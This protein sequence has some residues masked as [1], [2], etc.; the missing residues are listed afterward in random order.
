MGLFC[1]KLQKQKTDNQN[2]FFRSQGTFLSAEKSLNSTTKLYELLHIWKT[3]F[4]HRTPLV[5]LAVS[6]YLYTE[7]LHQILR[8]F[9]SHKCFCWPGQTKPVLHTRY[10]TR[11]QDW[12]LASESPPPTRK[13]QVC[14]DWSGRMHLFLFRIR[15]YFNIRSLFITHCITA[16][17]SSSVNV[18]FYSVD[19]SV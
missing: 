7:N 9:G 16:G 6:A 11:M 14:S 1:E 17:K 19:R 12:W 10:W 18:L 2:S 13:C 3:H 15:L 4:H 5:N 8:N